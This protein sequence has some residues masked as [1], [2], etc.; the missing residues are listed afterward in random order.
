MR[1]GGEGEGGR[2]RRG[3]NIWIFFFSHFRLN[4]TNIQYTYTYIVSRYNYRLNHRDRFSLLVNPPIVF[5]CD[6]IQFLPPTSL[7]TSSPI[8]TPTPSLS[9]P[10]STPSY[11]PSSN[12]S[13]TFSSSPAFP[14]TSASSSSLFSSSVPS[15]SQWGN[16]KEKGGERGGERGEKRQEKGS[17]LTP[18]NRP[19]SSPSP[20]NYNSPGGGRVDMTVQVYKLLSIIISIFFFFVKYIVCVYV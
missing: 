20:S 4:F 1:E 12:L 17:P 13:S 8:S 7:S 11:H 6:F 10:I 14:T 3:E 15:S 2:E 16:K 19:T 5:R 9:A 18:A